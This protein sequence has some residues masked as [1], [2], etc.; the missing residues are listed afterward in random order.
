MYL[1]WRLVSHHLCRF[2]GR[3]SRQHLVNLLN[4]SFLLSFFPSFFLSFFPSFSSLL[5]SFFFYFHFILLLLNKNLSR[6]SMDASSVFLYSPFLF[7]FFLLFSLLFFFSIVYFLPFPLF[8]H[9][10]YLFL[11]LLVKV[12][13]DSAVCDGGSGVLGH[14]IEYIQL[15]T[16]SSEPQVCK[17]CGLKYKKKAGFVATHH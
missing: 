3:L 17:Y 16:L 10:I 14:P 11:S 9:I 7:S 12:A 15:N 13:G 4:T 2:D 5:P 6:L 8:I 1:E